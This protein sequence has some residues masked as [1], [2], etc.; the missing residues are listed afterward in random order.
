MFFRF[1]LSEFPITITSE[2]AINK[3]P[4]IGFKNPSAAIGIATML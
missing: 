2:K 3:A 4:H 1:N